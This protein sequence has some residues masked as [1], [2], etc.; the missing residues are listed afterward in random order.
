MENLKK[1]GYLSFWPILSTATIIMT[2][3]FFAMSI[4]L[5]IDTLSSS[6]GTFADAASEMAVFALVSV[7]MFALGIPIFFRAR[8]EV[9]AATTLSY[10]PKHQEV[11]RVVA[12]TLQVAGSIYGTETTHTIA[13]E[14]PS[15]VREAIEVGSKQYS[16]VGE[17][18]VGLLTYK[19]RKERLYFVS[20][21][22]F[23]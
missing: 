12:K 6:D 17:S 1:R 21:E 11:V 4:Y 3:I 9:I 13:F 19:R 7:L 23:C 14:F 22:P 18:E 16:V 10:A 5:F 8:D 20:F 2:G 15:G